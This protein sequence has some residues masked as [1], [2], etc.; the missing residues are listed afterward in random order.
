MSDPEPYS[1][2]WHRERKKQRQEWQ[3]KMLGRWKSRL[4]QLFPTSIPDQKRWTD[5]DQI[6]DTISQAA[7]PGDQAHAWLNL[8]DSGDIDLY[9]ASAHEEDGC[10]LLETDP[11]QEAGTLVRPEYLEL[12]VPDE[13]GRL[14][15]FWLEAQQLPPSGV[16]DDRSGWIYEEVCELRP[17]DYKPRTVYDRGGTRNADG[18]IDSLPP[19]ARP[20]IRY[21][22]GSFLI[23][24]KASPYIQN[25]PPGSP[26]PADGI[27]A[28]MGPDEFRK[29]MRRLSEEV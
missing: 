8:P 13:D 11:D 2:E 27:H 6:A 29:F 22:E 21:F 5:P 1:N 16:Y 15:Y 10:V 26:G 23:S 25:V 12:N 20:V 9:G 14:A 7:L 3:D 24:C 28:D 19:T 18:S 4:D 17:G